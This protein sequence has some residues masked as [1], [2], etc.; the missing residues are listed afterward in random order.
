LIALFLA[1]L[2][3]CWAANIWS[4]QKIKQADK[5]ARDKHL[6]LFNQFLNIYLNYHNMNKLNESSKEE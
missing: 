4:E 5:D 3:F 1:Q 2:L 6:P